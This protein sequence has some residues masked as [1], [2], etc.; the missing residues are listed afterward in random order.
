MAAGDVTNE[1]LGSMSGASVYMAKVELNATET[2]A[3]TVTVPNVTDIKNVQITP[4]VAGLDAWV[5]VSGRVVT[6]DCANAVGGTNYVDLMVT[7]YGG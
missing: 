1:I 6:I 5:A 7:G 2:T 3:V 4:Y